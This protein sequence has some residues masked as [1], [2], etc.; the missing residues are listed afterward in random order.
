MR[1]PATRW[2]I[3]RHSFAAR[4]AIE[5]DHYDSR[6]DHRESVERLNWDAEEEHRGENE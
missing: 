4:S 6:E 2:R 3:W 1:S 5:E